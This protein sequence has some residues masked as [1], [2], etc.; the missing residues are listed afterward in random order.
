ELRF[1]RVAQQLSSRQACV[2]HVSSQK[3]TR[4]QNFLIFLPRK[5]EAAIQLATRK[6]RLE[7]VASG[8]W[9]MFA[10]RVA[11][12]PLGIDSLALR[13]HSKK[14]LALLNRASRAAIITLFGK[15]RPE[16]KSPE[17]LGAFVF[18]LTTSH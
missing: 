7:G 10:K 6:Q 8:Y 11:N 15:H 2:S 4:F 3:G 5:S 18:S 1:S 17:I 13:G 12:Q 16:R 14:S 9:T